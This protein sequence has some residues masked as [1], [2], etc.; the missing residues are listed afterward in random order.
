[1]VLYILIIAHLL[2][3]FT[4]QSTALADKKKEKF[5]YLIAHSIIYAATFAIACFT[6]IEFKNVIWF[7]IIIIFS[8]FLI[9]WVRIIIDCKFKKKSVVL[10]SFLIDQALH[11]AIII[12]S[13]YLF[14]LSIKTTC[15]YAFFQKREHFRALVV[16]MLVFV[17]IWDPTAVLIKKVFAYIIGDCDAQN[18]DDNPKIGS[19]IGKLERVIIS[20][21]VLCGQLGA[22]GF[23][24]TAKSI[25]R[26][27]QLEDQ[28]F[29]EKYLVGTLAS[30]SVSVI[31][32]I[33]LKSLL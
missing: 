6:L 10:A 14:G 21:L 9:D 5:V 29:A 15:V 1:M 12:A 25:A 13:Y 2:A 16:Y 4:F 23:V 28:N 8:H 24:L 26:Y 19:I 7:Y 32:A 30:T 31:T 3:D 22:I 33:L 18:K 11:I 20:T 27:K 17:I